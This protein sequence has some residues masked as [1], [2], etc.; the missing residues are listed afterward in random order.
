[1]LI[2]DI[3]IHAV[4]DVCD[5]KCSVIRGENLRK[6]FSEEREIVLKGC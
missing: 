5:L 1:M 6:L 3:E 2:L 4:F